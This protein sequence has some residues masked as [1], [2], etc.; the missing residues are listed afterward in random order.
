MR[1]LSDFLTSY[2][3]VL[4]DPPWRY[5]DKLRM[6]D[7]ARSSDDQ[8][9][10]MDVHDICALYRPS[11]L[12]WETQVK[13]PGLL[14]GH[15]IA[16][17]AFLYLWV[18][19]PFLLDGSGSMVCQA[20]GFEPKQLITWIKGRQSLEHPF[21][22]FQMGMGHYT[23]GVTEHLILATRGKC[24][25][26][27]KDHSVVNCLLASKNKHSAK[28]EAQYDLI[29]RVSPGPY[30]ELFARSTRPGWTA[31]GNQLAEVEEVIEWP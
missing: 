8:Y 15:R 9:P 17:H 12:D 5:D 16:E 13:T 30:L 1:D 28:P 14:A 26:L 18:T 29:E 19:N 4:A 10:T 25:A 31:W 27:V 3:T 20:W 7:V 24:K 22:T 23:R 6:S 21:I 11:V 2:T